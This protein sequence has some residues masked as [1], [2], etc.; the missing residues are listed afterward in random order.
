M[1]DKKKKIGRYYWTSVKIYNRFIAC[2]FDEEHMAETFKKKTWTRC[3][4]SA[5]GPAAWKDNKYE[6]NSK[7]IQVETDL[8]LLKRRRLYMSLN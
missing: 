7:R 6:R 3:V 4:L 1:N 5:R 8:I 2:S